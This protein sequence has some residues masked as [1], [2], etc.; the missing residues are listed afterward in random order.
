[1]GLVIIYGGRKRGN[2]FAHEGH[3]MMP[4]WLEIIW[5]LLSGR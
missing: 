2:N 5:N 3:A 1:M 4:P